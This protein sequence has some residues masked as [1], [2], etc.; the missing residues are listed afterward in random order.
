MEF[1]SH[2]FAALQLCVY[3]G[4]ELHTPILVCFKSR[5]S[6]QLEVQVLIGRALRLDWLPHFQQA[7][8]AIV[9]KAIEAKMVYPS[10][11]ECFLPHPGRKLDVDIVSPK[12]V[13]ANV[14]KQQSKS[15]AIKMPDIYTYLDPKKNQ[16]KIKV[17]AHYVDEILNKCNFARTRH[18]LHL[19]HLLTH[20][21]SSLVPKKRNRNP[22][23]SGLRVVRSKI[24]AW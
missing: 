5:P 22:L 10:R 17:V 8:S 24:S 6:V 1:F 19:L 23:H 16:K 3:A 11:M 4:E 20:T 12:T 9:E 13:T 21:Y 15:T 18:P 7:L 2:I 14:P